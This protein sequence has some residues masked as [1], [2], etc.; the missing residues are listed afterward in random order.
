[1]LGGGLRGKFYTKTHTNF[2]SQV[3]RHVGGVRCSRAGNDPSLLAN[4]SHR[5]AREVDRRHRAHRLEP[6]RFLQPR[7]DFLV[8]Q[9]QRGQP[10]FLLSALE[11]HQAHLSTLQFQSRQLARE[12]TRLEAIHPLRLLAAPS[13]A[14]TAHIVSSRLGSFN[15]ARTSSSVNG[16]RRRREMQ[17]RGE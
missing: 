14:A 10:V 5:A 12:R 9:R 8:R 4:L 6:T 16:S 1:M 3:G 17:P 2:R 13:T 15:P 7:A 11:T